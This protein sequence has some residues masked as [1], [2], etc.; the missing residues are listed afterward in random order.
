MGKSKR[1]FWGLD[2]ETSGTTHEDHVPIQLGI[3][4]PNGALFSSLIGGWDFDIVRDWDTGRRAKG[5]AWDERAFEVHKITQEQLIGA[6]LPREVSA[7]A[8]EFIEEHSQ[9]WKGE[10]KLV[11][12]NVASFDVPFLRKW[13]PGVAR[14]LSYQSAD[15]NAV[16]F[17]ISQAHGISFKEVKWRSKEYAASKLEELFAEEMWH[18][19][20]YDAAAALHSWA[21]L[22][23]RIKEGY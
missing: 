3:A 5:Y 11:G 1:E 20:G 19:A 16:C 4:A 15:L 10:R 9:A 21:Y 18:D 6:P 13:L 17:A 22:T 8:L 7:Q 23:E 2:F 14:E 12:W